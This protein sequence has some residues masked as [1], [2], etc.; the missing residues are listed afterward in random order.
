MLRVFLPLSFALAILHAAAADDAVDFNRDIRP[1]LSDTCFAC[2]GPDSRQRQA[3][4]RLDVRDI[5]V[6]KLES[7]A[8]AI[9]PGDVKAS[10]LVR[11]ITTSSDDERM[12]PL[13]SGKQLTPSQIEKLTKWVAQGAKYSAHWSFVAPQRPKLPEVQ[14]KK[15]PRNDIDYFILARLEHE[16]LHPSPEAAKE[17]LLRRLSLDL[18]GLPPTLAELDAF[19]ADSSPEAYEKQVDRLL[20]SPHYGER[21]AMAWLDGARYADSNGYQDDS[22]RFMWPWR[23]WVIKAFNRNLPFDQFTIEQLAGDMLPSATRDQRIATGFNRNHRLTSEGGSIAE[24]WRV[25]TVIDRV[26]TTS[27]VWLGLTAGCA[28][29]H[30]HKYD[31][32]T[33]KEFY[34]L[35]A[36]FNNVPESGMAI[37]GAKNTPPV[38]GATGEAHEEQLKSLDA[39][40]ATARAEIEKLETTVLP[41]K[42]AE[43]EK[44]IAADGA[45]K[46]VW[47][48]VAPR[49]SSS[50]AKATFTIGAD[51]TIQVAGP[52]GATDVYSFTLSTELKKVSAVRLE[53]L[54]D[55][56]TSAKGLGRSV[57]GNFVMTNLRL[58]AAG[59][60]VRLAQATSDFSQSGFPVANA[61]DAD[62][63]TGWAIHPK[64]HEPHWGV[65]STEA[66]VTSDKPIELSL[67]LHF[68]SQYG[69]HQPSRFRLYATDSP[70]PHEDGAVPANISAILQTPADKR[71]QEQ[72]KQLLDYVRPRLGGEVTAADAKLQAAVKAKADYEAN[73]PTV[74]V[75]EEMP[76]PRE[77]FVLKRGQ[78]DQRGDKVVAALP[79][80]LPP[81]PEGAKADRLGF[82]RWLVDPRH[83]LTA[84]VQVNRYWEKFFGTGLV[85]TSE[86]MGSQAEFP[87]HPELLDYLATEFIRLKWDMKAMQKQIVMSAA[88]RQ[89]SHVTPA[90][91]EKDPDN[92][93]LA[94]GPRFRLSGELVRDNALSIAGLLVPK[95]GGPS[96]RPYMPEGVWNETSVYGNLLNY[97][98]EK[99]DGLYRRTMY[100]IWKRTAAPPTM[101]MFDSPSREFCAVKRSR[102]NTPLQALSL[103]NE[104]TFVEAARALGQK[105]ITA[106]GSSDAD[107]VV[108]AFRRAA[109]RGPTAEELKVLLTGLARRRDKL[110]KD[111]DAAQKL[112]GVGDT[113]TANV[114]PVELAVYT[115][116]ANVILNLDEVVTKE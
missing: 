109:S 51:K 11:R 36:I 45:K 55:E 31:P 27:L 1:I 35:F 63:S 33:Q 34:Q 61:I 60:D 39:A 23:D 20:N 67:H 30:D 70:A 84:R 7:G 26:E 2:H 16:G 54:V 13:K 12:P 14:D 87:S 28:R 89:S 69:Q 95:I 59:K 64:T 100:T 113:P 79:A 65:F 44:S 25:E 10:E 6:G 91:I 75:M 81:L 3:G 110:Q 104:V 105:M 42:L 46:T 86:N 99:G 83:P 24:E 80:A 56:T 108:Y 115:L 8:T 92:R 103:L 73:L 21:M 57:N 37:G 53:L 50:T 93:L 98:H 76:Q 85:K 48:A 29:C 88:Y 17:T 74:M 40:V 90:L 72:K 22:E 71:N 15:W 47:Q 68:N 66:L 4:L 102:T 107:R 101:L 52:N 114:D 18:T 62:P 58:Q 94:R 43:W 116:T 32:L 49:E 97:Q 82:A 78:Y 41:Q 19:L 106:G 111:P 5:A 96:V 9:V 38:I 112:V 77:A